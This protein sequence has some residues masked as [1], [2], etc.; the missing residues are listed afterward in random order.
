MK[1]A[2]TILQQGETEN[3]RGSRRPAQ[4]DNEGL[5]I[6]QMWCVVYRRRKV[7]KC[8]GRNYKAV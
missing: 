7:K 5:T 2:I 1:A 4:S 6:W 3:L 8:K